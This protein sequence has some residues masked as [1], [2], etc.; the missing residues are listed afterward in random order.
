M[1]FYQKTLIRKNDTRVK[2]T[3][4]P[5]TSIVVAITGPD[6]TAGSTLIDFKANGVNVPIMVAIVILIVIAKPT[7]IPR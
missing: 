6:A 3:A 2:Y 4:S 5:T 7:T 1:Y